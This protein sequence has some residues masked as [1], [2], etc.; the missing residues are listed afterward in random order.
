[1]QHQ[2]LRTIAGSAIPADL[3]TAAAEASGGDD[4]SA[5][6]PPSPPA[7]VATNGAA[8]NGSA[9]TGAVSNGAKRGQQHPVDVRQILS[10]PGIEGDTLQFL[11][12]SEAYWKAL[13]NSRH[14][15]GK[16]GPTVVKK[17]FRAIGATEY[18]VCVAGGTLGIFLALA[19]QLRG[20]RVCVVERRVVEGRTQEWN[21]SRHELR[22]LSD[23]GLVTQAELEAAIVTEW[24][25][26]RVGFVGQRDDLWVD[27]VLNIGVDPRQLI[28]RM[29]ERFLAAGGAVY[30]RST[31][32]GA[33]T[34]PDGVLIKL[35]GEG[36]ASPATVGD[37]NRP[38]A[39][40]PEDYAEAD[41]VTAAERDAGSRGSSTH[42]SSSSGS[43][44]SSSGGRATAAT[45]AS[46]NGSSVSGGS[47]RNGVSY[48]TGTR[49]AGK[50]KRE[51]QTITARLLVDCMGHYS[52]IVKQVRGG[53]KPEAMVLVVGSCATGV[54]AA[55]NKTGDLLY[56][57]TEAEGDLQMFW[58]A[59]P[60]CGGTA[61]TTYM[62]AYADA[63]PR[64]PSFEALLQK[65]FALLPLYQ[66]VPL[67]TLK[68][69]R[70]LFGAF[71][72]YADAPLQPQFDRVLQI[73]D[74]AAAQSPLSFGG[75]GALVKALPRLAAGVGEALQD[76]RLDRR[77]LGL[78]QPY[79]PS[80]SAAWLFQR[81]MALKVG[82][83][84]EA[85]PAKGQPRRRGGVSPD[86]VNRLMRC[87]FSVMRRLG[88]WVL[89]PF[90]QDTIKFL[91][92]AVSMLGM[93]ACDPLVVFRV[94]CQV[95]PKTLLSWVRHYFSLATYAL[96]HTVVGRWAA[97][98]RYFRLR[99][100]ADAWRAGSGHGGAGAGSAPPVA[101]AAAESDGE[102]S[103]PA[104]AAA[105]PTAA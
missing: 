90:L 98:S 53:A 71:P 35:S 2:R 102:A 12:V 47:G 100:W 91:P 42:S 13:R 27:D 103:M 44:A 105:Q 21:I 46:L 20:Q 36:V 85:A 60:A 51:R 72:C 45:A 4:A 55:A 86:H 23:L 80:L 26:M 10:D 93:S 11:K 5:D 17:V 73:G 19:L 18:D 58:E 6:A 56:T 41:D 39:M 16:R 8:T 15:P 64:R 61:R 43:S 49:A 78:L 59:F 62:F 94:V 84:Q 75:F 28:A 22:T 81:S 76:D 82:A 89:R 68:L 74:A 63:D 92:L 52:P 79:Q 54:P 48:S 1:M 88:D 104:T 38:S 50:G 25:P 70:V 87:N 24:N 96:L 14:N 40:R 37:T 7:S 31:F 9:E 32:V 69:K 30:E 77:S 83:L 99:R 66:G 57:F 3:A 33:E 34:A 97:A 65:Y 95:G 29:R 67:E 101:A